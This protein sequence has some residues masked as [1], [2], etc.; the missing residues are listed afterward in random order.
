MHLDIAFNMRNPDWG[1]P[2]PDLYAA[3][4]EMSAWADRLGFETVVLSEHH[5]TSDGY[6]PSPIVLAAAVAARTER[7]AIKLGVVLASLV[8]PVHL[9]EDLAVA[10]LVSGGRLHVT[11]G[12]GYR[13]EEFRVFDVNWKRRPSI[14]TEVV[15][16][17]RTAWTGEGFDFRGMPVRVL[18]RPARPGGPPLALA[19]TSDGSARRAAALGL[20]YEPLGER[21]YQVYLEELARL[22]RP[23]P[24]PRRGEGRPT[25]PHFV[26]VARDPERYWAAAGPHVLHNV[27][28][29]ASYAQRKDLTPFQAAADPDALLRSGEAKVYT[30]EELVDTCRAMG[31]DGVVHLTPLE[32]GLPPDLAWESLHLFE[33]EVLPHLPP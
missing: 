27:N 8:H 7:V 31:P 12:A 23:L 26:A 16:T 9:A 21:F 5:N 33:A 6:L 14:M 20:A 15:E 13:K 30:P 29:Y 19:G 3:A 24:P 10:D 1:A 4:L 17:L 11:L 32:G 18:P 22:G 25:L 2:G 28:E